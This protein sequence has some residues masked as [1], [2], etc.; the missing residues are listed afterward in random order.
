MKAAPPSRSQ[1]LVIVDSARVMQTNFLAACNDGHMSI[2]LHCC[3]S[4]R[5]TKGSSWRA[6]SF[7]FKAWAEHMMIL[8]LAA[9]RCF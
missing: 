6:I 2:I 1:V 4:M 8:W 7:D 3:V 9:Q 5:G